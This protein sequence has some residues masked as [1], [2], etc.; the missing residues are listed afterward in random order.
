ME[1]R[2]P[3]G[4]D[5][6]PAGRR[7]RSS[8]GGHPRA[9]RSARCSAR[10]AHERARRGGVVCRSWC[11]FDGHRGRARR[12]RDE[13]PDEVRVPLPRHVPA[14]DGVAGS[15]RV[16]E[17][18]ETTTSAPRRWPTSSRT[19]RASRTRRRPASPQRPGSVSSSSSIPNSAAAATA[20][21]RDR[22]GD[23]GPIASGCRRASLPASRRASGRMTTPSSSERRTPMPGPRSTFRLRLG[24]L[25]GDALHQLGL[26]ARQREPHLAGE[27][28][29]H[30][31]RPVPRRPGSGR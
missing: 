12:R 17:G 1:M 27:R 7:W 26:R 8:A 4:R 11:R 18:A 10:P 2:P 15:E 5:L 16:M 22:D 24:D 21:L 28:A 3:I 31:D 30:R 19:T 25:R 14:T 20:V 23:D 13:S 6:F 29:A 9:P